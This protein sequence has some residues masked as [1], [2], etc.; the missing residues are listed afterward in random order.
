MTKPTTRLRIASLLCF[1]SEPLLSILNVFG[2]CFLREFICD[3]DHT[4]KKSFEYLENA[5]RGL[6]HNRFSKYWL[7]NTVFEYLENAHRGLRHNRFS[8]WR[9]R[10]TPR[11]TPQSFLFR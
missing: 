11:P 5:H 3:L 4:K 6:H 2:W 10:N 7:R 8:K 1:K 9:L